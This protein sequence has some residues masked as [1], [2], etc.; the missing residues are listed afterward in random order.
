M[1]LALINLYAPT[2]NACSIYVFLSV[3]ALLRT[4]KCFDKMSL[5]K[6]LH[7]SN[8]VMHMRVNFGQIIFQLI[9]W[10]VIVYTADQDHYF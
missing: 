9:E 8:M 4:Q 2:K 1:K 3:A 6:H 10:V 7:Y 5:F